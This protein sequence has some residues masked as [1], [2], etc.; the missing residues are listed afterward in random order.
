MNEKPSFDISIL[1]AFSV[2]LI[3]DQSSSHASTVIEVS[4]IGATD[5]S[6]SSPT[7][8]GSE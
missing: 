5:E 7:F 6:N 3:N 2:S 1:K 8:F 4:H